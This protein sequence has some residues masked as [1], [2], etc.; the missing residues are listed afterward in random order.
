M[1]HFVDVVVGKAQPRLTHDDVRKVTLIA[2]AAEKSAELGKPV[3]MDYN[4]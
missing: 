2:E 1:D 4:V 3:K